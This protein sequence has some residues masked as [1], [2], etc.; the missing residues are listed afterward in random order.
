MRS[1]T[2]T[3]LVLG[4]DGLNLVTWIKYFLEH[5]G[6]N[7]EIKTEKDNNICILLD[8]NDMEGFY[9]ND[10]VVNLDLNMKLMCFPADDM[11]GDHFTKTLQEQKCCKSRPLIIG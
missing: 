5:Q 1:S 9:V 4:H 2:K 8:K 6:C 11:I 7:V 10:V 3:E